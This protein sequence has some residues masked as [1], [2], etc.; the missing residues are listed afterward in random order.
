MTEGKLFLDTICREQIPLCQEI[1]SKYLFLL[2]KV[3]ITHELLLKT[4]QHNYTDNM[5]SSID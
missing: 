4:G 1:I 2:T 5:M 3:D